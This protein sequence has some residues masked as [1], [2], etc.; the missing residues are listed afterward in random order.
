MYSVRFLSADDIDIPQVQIG[1]QVYHLPHK[2]HY[3]F[4]RAIA[5]L[6]GS[7]ASNIHDEEPAI[8][9]LEYSDDEAERA[10]KQ[11]FFRL[12]TVY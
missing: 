3:A 1:R 6:K 11:R 4:P 8:V 12:C 5:M 2:S 7:D 9:E 10:A